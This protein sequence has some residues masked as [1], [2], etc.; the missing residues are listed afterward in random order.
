MTEFQQDLINNA[1]KIA[2]GSF[3]IGTIIFV[4]FLLISFKPLVFLGFLFLLL[5]ILANGTMLFFLIYLW[6]L[7]KKERLEIGKVILLVIA[8]IP[9]A[10]VFAYISLNLFTKRFG[11]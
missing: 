2:K 8:N 11:M 1:K 7:R 3:I 5:A 9:I 6:F 10:F 4:T